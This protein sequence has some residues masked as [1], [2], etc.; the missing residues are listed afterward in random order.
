MSGAV[1]GTSN[2]GDGVH[3]VHGRPQVDPKE[4]VKDDNRDNNAV[5]AF[6]EPGKQTG[7]AH[8]VA[9]ATGA[10]GGQPQP[11]GREVWGNGGDGG[12]ASSNKAQMK[13]KPLNGSKGESTRSIEGDSPVWSIGVG[14]SI[15]DELG[16][17]NGGS[18]GDG[19]SNGGSG[20]VRPF[21]YDD[22]SNDDD[23][24]AVRFRNGSVHSEDGGVLSR[25]GAIAKGGDGGNSGKKKSRWDSIRSLVARRNSPDANVFGGG[26]NPNGVDAYKRPPYGGGIRKIRSNARWNTDAGGAGG[27]KRRGKVVTAEGGGGNDDGVSRSHSDSRSFSSLSSPG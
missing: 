7:D 26:N 18:N 20:A 25:G 3:G 23:D 8:G 19:G 4:A 10:N 12:G 9:D 16:S 2:I 13:P 5:S 1:P 15:S 14:R 6:T 22:D 24:L 21:S 27:I 11:L 17:F